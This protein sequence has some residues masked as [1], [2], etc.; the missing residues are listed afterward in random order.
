M[1][2]KT[3]RVAAKPQLNQQEMK[4]LLEGNP[5]E[6]QEGAAEEDPDADRIGGVGFRR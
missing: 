6:L 3:V 5:D 1:K 4:K 2:P